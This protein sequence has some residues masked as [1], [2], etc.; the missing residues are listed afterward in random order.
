MGLGL[1]LRGQYAATRNDVRIFPSYPDAALGA[2][3]RRSHWDVLRPTC[4]APGRAF[5]YEIGVPSHPRLSKSKFVTGLQCHKRLWWQTHEPGAPELAVGPDLQA[6]FDAGTRVGEAARD[7]VPGGVLIDAPYTRPRE[8]VAQTRRALDDG[9]RVLYEAAFFE[10]DIFVAVD[11]L[12]L[13]GGGR[14][15]L[16]EVKSTVR[17]KPEHLPDA[18]VQTHVLRRAGLAVDRVELMHLDAACTFPDLSNLFHRA[19]VTDDVEALVGDVPREARRQLAM[20]RGPLPE[21][22]AGAH[23]DAPYPCPFV[24][25]CRPALPEHHVSTLHSIRAPRLAQLLSDGYETLYDLPAGLELTAVQ[26]RQRR[27]VQSGALVVEPTLG[28]ALDALRAPVAYLDFETV[29]LGIP[30][31]NGCHPYQN[32]PVQWSVHLARAD[33]TVEHHAWLATG[34]GDPRPGCAAALAPVLA[35]A[36]TV[37][38]YYSPFEQGCLEM[39]AAAAPEHAAALLGAVTRLVDLLPIVRQHVYDPAFGGHFGLKIVLP[40][41]VAGLGY[42]DLSIAEGGVASS[43]LQRLMFDATLP[44]DERAGL[45]EAL[46][47][48]CSRDTEA[49]VRMVERLRALAPRSARPARGPGPRSGIAPPVRSAQ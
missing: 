45:R 2:S 35:S 43:E 18:A 20:L 42:G 13:R 5:R 36:E 27:A 34:P 23:C 49:L 16:T 11:I 4:R 37:V 40:A 46:L 38:A 21:V 12:S 48:Y 9:A 33:G 6:T 28:A 47:A 26:E 10:D 17:V 31:W 25:R 30:A 39:L 3:D 19:D 15:T 24:G 32:V 44:A 14:A 29:A 1:G 8:R 41:L 7:H 22:E